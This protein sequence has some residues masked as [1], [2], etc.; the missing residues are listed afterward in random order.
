[1][2]KFSGTEPGVFGHFISKVHV[3]YSNVGYVRGLGLCNFKIQRF[4]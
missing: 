2:V 4:W 3:G 1:V